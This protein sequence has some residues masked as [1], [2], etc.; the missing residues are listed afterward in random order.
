MP[1]NLAAPAVYPPEPASAIGALVEE[2]RLDPKLGSQLLYSTHL[3]GSEARFGELDPPL[4]EPIARA[5]GR[6]GVPRLWQHQTDGIA[7]VRR[8]ENVL[9]TTPTASG[10]S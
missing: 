10:K 3:P 6:G 9:I 5:L 4:A 8:G 2:L 1:R 7:A